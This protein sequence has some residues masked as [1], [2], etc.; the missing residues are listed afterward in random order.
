M[1]QTYNFS[2][3][4]FRLFGTIGRLLFNF[5]NSFAKNGK[6]CKIIKSVDQE[7]GFEA[8]I[9]YIMVATPIIF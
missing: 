5:S 1:I 6:K 9:S 8:G 2:E 7:T 3:K 4:A